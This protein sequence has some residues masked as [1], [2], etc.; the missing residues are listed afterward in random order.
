MKRSSVNA[1]KK[2]IWLRLQAYVGD[3]EIWETEITEENWKP[4]AFEKALTSIFNQLEKK[5]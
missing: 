5:L 3:P 2:E 4:A 1:A